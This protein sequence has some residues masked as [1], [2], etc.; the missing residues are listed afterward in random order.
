MLRPTLSLPAEDRP[1]IFP[2]P[3]TLPRK[4]TAMPSTRILI[5]DNHAR[6]ARLL[7]GALNRE[8]DIDCIGYATGTEAA[9]RLYLELKPDVV[10]MDHELGDGTGLDAAQR[11]LAHDPSARIVLLTAQPSSSLLQQG[12]TLGIRAVLAK[13]GSLTT[14]LNALRQAARPVLRSRRTPS[15]A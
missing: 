5:V 6:F 7:M 3:Q 15:A 8:R 1:T 11:I 14:L 4:A 13:G 2:A 10:M 12:R 9:L